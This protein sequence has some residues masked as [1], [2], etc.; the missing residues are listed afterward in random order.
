MLGGISLACLPI[1]AWQWGWKHNNIEKKE[2]FWVK[3]HSRK[4]LPGIGTVSYRPFTQSI[5]WKLESQNLIGQSRK[6]NWCFELQFAW[7]DT[8]QEFER[9]DIS[10]FLDSLFT[11]YMWRKLFLHFIFFT[12]NLHNNSLFFHQM[13]ALPFCIFKFSSSHHCSLFHLFVLKFTL[14]LQSRSTD[15]KRPCYKAACKT[16]CIL[17]CAR[18]NS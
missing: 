15:S 1:F 7:A 13:I 16:K 17:G 14:N 18:I 5:Y 9:A 2:A 4:W 11:I 10:S 3:P 8:L 12:I 6:A